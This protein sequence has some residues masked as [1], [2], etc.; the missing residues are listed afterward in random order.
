M[1]IN[2]DTQLFLIVLCLVFDRQD[3][4]ELVSYIAKS[5]VILTLFYG[6]NNAEENPMLTIIRQEDVELL[7]VVFWDWIRKNKW[8]WLGINK[9]I[10]LKHSL[11]ALFSITK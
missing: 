5:V 11:K 2:N 8:D 7:N 1:E 3:V 4:V 6:K 10:S 9:V